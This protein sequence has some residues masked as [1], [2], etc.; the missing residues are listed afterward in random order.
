MQLFLKDFDRN[1][2]SAYHQ[3]ILLQGHSYCTYYIYCKHINFTDF[4]RKQ[5]ETSA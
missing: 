2:F 4:I 1:T 5:K 3:V